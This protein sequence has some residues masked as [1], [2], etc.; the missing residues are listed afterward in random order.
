M[1]CRMV[2]HGSLQGFCFRSVFPPVLSCQRAS[3]PMPP[4]IS[5]SH[6]DTHTTTAAAADVPLPVVGGYL[7]FVGWFCVVAG[8]CTFVWCL[9]HWVKVSPAHSS[10]AAL[11]RALPSS[12]PTHHR[13]AGISLTTGIQFSGLKSWAQLASGDALLKLTPA[14]G[15]VVLISLVLRRY[16]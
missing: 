16:R 14:I 6:T 12:P 9:R 4:W 7:A 2:C 15:M 5:L 8:E 10:F 13:R 1:L 3:S 11:L